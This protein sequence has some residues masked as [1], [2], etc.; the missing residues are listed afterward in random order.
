MSRAAFILAA[1]IAVA[2]GPVWAACPNVTVRSI[3][4]TLQVYDPF[5]PGPTQL[6]FE[7]QVRNGGEAACPI[8]LVMR[9][10]GGGLELSGAGGSIPYAFIEPGGLQSG[11][12]VGPL[13]L[14]VPPHED[15]SVAFRA[16][17]PIGSVVAPG[18]YEQALDLVVTNDGDTLA[19]RPI[20]LSAMVSAR[21]QMSISGA[22]APGRGS[23]GM[24]PP[25]IDFQTLEAGEQ[26]RVYINAWAN[27]SVQISLRSDHG[28]VMQH[29][30]GRRLPPVPYSIVFDG[31][32]QSLNAPVVISRTPPMS[33]SGASY[34]L[35]I[36]VG[37]VRGRYAGRYS[38]IITVT[39]DP[40]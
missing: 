35:V 11:N 17:L 4:P 1:L 28:G 33:L 36:T 19:D 20:S 21:A 12:V 25:S 2:A 3:S 34:P 8:E 22:S 29:E 9:P 7:V 18:T 24:A 27:T 32:P 40:L 15:R 39:V 13:T 23:V 38:D 6:S 10:A 37:D 31:E 16:E 30:D 5:A 14:Q 26:A